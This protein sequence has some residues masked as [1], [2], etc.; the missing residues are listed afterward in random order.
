M[1]EP[2]IGCLYHLRTH[3]PFISCNTPPIQEGLLQRG[4]ENTAAVGQIGVWQNGG[5]QQRVVSF[6]FPVQPPKMGTLKKGGQTPNSEVV[7]QRNGVHS[8]QAKAR[9]WFLLL[10]FGDWPKQQDEL[11]PAQSS[12]RVQQIRSTQR[13]RW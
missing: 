11:P 9:I 5:T 2:G 10:A 6:G 7:M 3:R 1:F 13:P 4:P 12:A 8:P